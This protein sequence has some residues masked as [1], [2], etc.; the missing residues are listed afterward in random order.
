MALQKK[1]LII[2]MH[3]SGRTVQEIAKALHCM[4]RNVLDALEN[5]GISIESYSENTKQNDYGAR[6]SGILRFK[7]LESAKDSVAKIDRL[8]HEYAVAKDRRG[9]HQAQL[10]ALIAKNRAEGIEKWEVAKLFAEWLIEHLYIEPK[11]SK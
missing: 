1:N 4:P 2:A 11:E 8:F 10:I 7:T 3:N 6:F 5:A 9:Q